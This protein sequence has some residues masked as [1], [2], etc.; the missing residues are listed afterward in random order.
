[1][2]SDQYA[3]HIW[4]QREGEHSDRDDRNRLEEDVDDRHY[5]DQEHQVDIVG[6]PG[7]NNEWEEGN[8]NWGGGDDDEGF[9][10]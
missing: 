5:D 4:E 8:E 3:S 2:D 6:E 10:S 7:G 1:M 9:D